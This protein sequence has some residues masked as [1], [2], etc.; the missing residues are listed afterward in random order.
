[1]PNALDDDRCGVQ[2]SEDY[3]GDHDMLYTNV[4]FARLKKQSL[5]YG[6]IPDGD[7]I[8]YRDVEAGKESPE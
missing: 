7:P 4:K 8:D 2:W 5:F 3:D 1:M 6:I